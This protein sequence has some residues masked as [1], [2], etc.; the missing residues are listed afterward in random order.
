MKISPATQNSR[1]GW[2]KQPGVRHLSEKVHKAVTGWVTLEGT[3][4]TLVWADVHT[5]GRALLIAIW[6]GHLCL[7]LPSAEARK[8]LSRL[9]REQGSTSGNPSAHFL[10]GLVR[11]PWLVAG[12][13]DTGVS[14][15]VLDQRS[16]ILRPSTRTPAWLAVPGRHRG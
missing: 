11:P 4:V 14:L 5:A 12:K 9:P 15:S 3:Q 2:F 6:R 1:L 10:S 8:E 13:G 7:A 16:R